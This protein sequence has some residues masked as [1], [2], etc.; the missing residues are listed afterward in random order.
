MEY[1]LPSS[2]LAT[3]TGLGTGRR[4]PLNTRSINNMVS[5][6]PTFGFSI[7]KRFP[8]AFVPQLIRTRYFND[9]APVT[10]KGLIQWMNGLR[11]IAAI[12]VFNHHFLVRS[13]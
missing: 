13:L 4:W 5:S 7:V 10:K 12:A 6:F 2:N 8:Y 3:S 11:G 9:P 1:L